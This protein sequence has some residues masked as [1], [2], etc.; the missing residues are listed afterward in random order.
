MRD[1]D[2]LK[3]VL[4][5]DAKRAEARSDV[6]ARNAWMVL[7]DLLL[8]PAGGHEFNDLFD[9]QLRSPQKRKDPRNYAC[10]QRIARVF[11]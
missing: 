7:D 8:R 11:G 10:F 5:S 3:P 6:V 2:R 9:R 1:P 4:R